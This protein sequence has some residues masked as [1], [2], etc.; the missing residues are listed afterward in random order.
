M[1]RMQLSVFILFLI[2]AILIAGV[3]IFRQGPDQD[4]SPSG[5]FVV[6]KK[7]NP[8]LKFF[9]N[10]IG[11][12]I[13]NIKSRSG[14]TKYYGSDNLLYNAGYCGQCTWYVYGR[15]YE[16]QGIQL[17]IARNAKYWL[18]DNASD[19]ALKVVFGADHIS[20]KAIA[21]RTTGNYGHVMFV[22]YVERNSDGSPVN[23][24]FT[25]CNTD[26][27]GTYDIGKDCIIQCKSFAQFKSENNPA[28]YI[29]KK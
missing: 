21:V 1:K 6:N 10:S 16:V 7:K 18:S 14:Y 22:E 24:Y 4:G 11:Q 27:N 19:S 25:E 13:P 23:V 12:T 28:G 20:G 26:N 5:D 8:K 29:C 15:F 3:I 17:K 2:S 9:E